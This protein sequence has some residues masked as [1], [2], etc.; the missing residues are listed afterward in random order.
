MK[1]LQINTSYINGG[2][3]GRIVY[4]LSQVIQKENIESY[5]GFGYEYVQTNDVNTYKIETIPELKLS[6]LK[7][8]LF[9]KH[10]FYNKGVTRNFL[11][12][13]DKIKP[14]V[15][16]L[17]NL[18]NHYL[19]IEILFEYI[20]KHDI[21]VVW[22]LH[23]CWS[24]TGWCAYFDY[25]NCDKWLTGCHNCPSLRDYPYTWFFDRSKEIYNDKAKIFGDVNNL[26]IITPSN[27][28]AKLVKQSIL[29]EY[30]VKVINNG[31][32]LMAFKPTASD[33][34]KNNGLEN[35]II[36]LAMA[37]QL[38]KR[39]G[40]DYLLRLPALLSDDYCLVL[41]GIEESQRKFL[42]AK[43]CI[44]IKKTN[45]ID[46]LVQIYSA[47]DMFVNPTLED[48]FPTTNLEA[49]ACGTPVITFNTGG[50]PESVDESV[51]VVVKKG[52]MDELVNAIKKVSEIGKEK[53]TAL[54]VERANLYYGKEK[55]YLKY[56]EEYKLL[57]NL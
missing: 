34:R 9:G 45:N 48:N 3:T 1:I 52:S 12:W 13:V 54:C 39:K 32:D 16:H 11:D 15:I 37:M 24:F 30:V 56:I 25:S 43:N 26:T 5:V 28:L 55:Q 46:E 2:S 19:N 21:P 8:R 7:T 50:S 14:D 20:K 18:H 44:G 17:H 36:V 31:I 29:K 27:W 47:S 10:G 33:F 49:L 51:G 41:V 53:Y 42:P 40:V 35:K 57:T 6:I 22:T 23:D 38:N 4:D